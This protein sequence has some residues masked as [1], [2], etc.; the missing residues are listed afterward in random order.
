[1]QA[2][3]K[4]N[5]HRLWA[6]MCQSQNNRSII[7]QMQTKLYPCKVILDLQS[8]VLK[9]NETDANLTVVWVSGFLVTADNCVHVGGLLTFTDLT[10]P[11]NALY[12][13]CILTECF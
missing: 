4:I 2:C 9:Q 8:S 7:K 6:Q 10:V 1:M 13:N 11:H 5:W 12:T 3:I